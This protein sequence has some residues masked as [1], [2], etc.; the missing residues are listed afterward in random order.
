MKKYLVGGLIGFVSACLLG[1]LTMFLAF[2][3][4]FEAWLLTM[5]AELNASLS[6]FPEEIA[7]YSDSGENFD[8]MYQLDAKFLDDYSIIPEY[9]GFSLIREQPVREFSKTDFRAVC[10]KSIRDFHM[11]FAVTLDE[12]SRTTLKDSFAE[13][14]PDFSYSP[15]ES[16]YRKHYF[17]VAV[18]DLIASFWVTGEGAQGYADAVT[19]NP[20]QPDF[21]LAVPFNQ[22]NNFGSYLANWMV[23]E[24]PVGCTPDIDPSSLPGWD[25]IVGLHWEQ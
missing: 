13:N 5:N 7:F 18:G 17:F 2:G 22:L 10:V 19:E 23:N 20:D 8:T 14:G 3:Y 12:D 25:T 24:P 11:D 16:G 6:D 21:L 1:L 9:R 15:A 4:S